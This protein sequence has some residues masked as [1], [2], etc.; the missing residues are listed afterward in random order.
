MS[1]LPEGALSPGMPNITMPGA[2][3]LASPGILADKPRASLSLTG[4]SSANS[5]WQTFTESV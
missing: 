3:A 5:H 4:D 2:G 1:P